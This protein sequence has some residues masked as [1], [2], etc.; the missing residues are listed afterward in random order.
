MEEY[1]KQ[2]LR[3]QKEANEISKEILKQQHSEIVVSKK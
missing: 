2:S 1:A 3:V